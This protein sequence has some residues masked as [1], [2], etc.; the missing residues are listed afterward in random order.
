MSAPINIIFCVPTNSE[1]QIIA[2]I[3]P[4]VLL[5]LVV[6]AGESS[7]CLCWPVEM[8]GNHQHVSADLWRF[9]PTWSDQRGMCV[10]CVS[11]DPPA[12]SDLPR[13]VLSPRQR[14]C[15]NWKRLKSAPCWCG[16]GKDSISTQ[17]VQEEVA[18]I[19]HMHRC[20]ENHRFV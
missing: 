8:Q 19:P 14:I 12:Y 9:D 18:C 13:F 10:L 3:L 20:I 5:S 6:S 1:S 16:L 11:K 2:M 15:Y 4:F 7:A 17:R